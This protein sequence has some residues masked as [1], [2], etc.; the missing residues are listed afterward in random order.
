VC[1]KARVERCST[2]AEC[3]RAI[4]STNRCSD[5]KEVNSVLGG[6]GFIA[7]PSPKRLV[8]C[9]RCRYTAKGQRMLHWRIA[10]SLEA[11]GRR[12]LHLEIRLASGPSC[13]IMCASRHAGQRHGRVAADRDHVERGAI[14]ISVPWSPSASR[15][16][17][18]FHDLEVVHGG[19]RAVRG[20]SVPAIRGK[21]LKADTGPC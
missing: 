18:T 14:E 13:Q 6:S 8:V 5:S 17:Q 9:N 15:F 3:K 12:D 1:S 4:E 11:A 20:R 7:D 16:K 2:R 10:R 19:R 21:R